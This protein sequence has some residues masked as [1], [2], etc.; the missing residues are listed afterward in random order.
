MAILILKGFFKPKERKKTPLFMPKSIG[1]GIVEFITDLAEE[2]KI[3]GLAVKSR[4]YI[5][6]TMILL[7]SCSIKYL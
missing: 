7:K 5:I 6:K 2:R 3:Y 4:K 1:K